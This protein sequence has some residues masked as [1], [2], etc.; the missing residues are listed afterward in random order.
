MTND[1][2]TLIENSNM[3]PKEV[4]RLI[5]ITLSDIHEKLNELAADMD[6]LRQETESVTQ[7]RDKYP[8]I[9]WLWS[10]RRKDLMI[11]MVIVFL[12]Y[13]LLVTPY[14]IQEIRNSILGLALGG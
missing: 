9:T 5:L 13:T 8:S 4:D 14:N 1:I 7:Y 11:I 10:H 12:I 6:S 2:R 3:E